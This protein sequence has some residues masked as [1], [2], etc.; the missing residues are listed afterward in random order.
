[1]PPWRLRHQRGNEE[2]QTDGWSYRASAE[3][4]LVSRDSVAQPVALCT[5]W[6]ISAIL[7]Q[8]R[9]RADQFDIAQPWVFY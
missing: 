4:W 3:G 2:T 8:D 1:M 7:L 9:R 5:K 6:K